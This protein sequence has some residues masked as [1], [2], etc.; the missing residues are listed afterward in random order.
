MSDVLVYVILGITAGSV[1]GLAGVGL[2]LTYRTSG[3]LNF[4]HGALAT[5]GSYLF[6]ELW[7]QA[8]LPWPVAGFLAVVVFGSLLGL[9][10]ELLARRLTTVPS[11]IVVV[12]TVGVLLGITGL[13]T[14]RYTSATLTLDHYLSQSTFEVGGVFISWEQL[15]IV[16][17]GI[18]VAGSM[19]W[20][21][22]HTRIGT[23]MRGVVDDP[24]LLELTGFDAARVRRLAW[25]LGGMVACFS[26]VLIAPTIGLNP[27]LLTYLVVQAFGAAAIGRFKSLPLTFVGGWIIGIVAAWGGKYANQYPVLL[28]LPASVPF[29]AL[30]VVLIISKPGSLPGSEL[31]RRI[32]TERFSALPTPVVAVL[33]FAA[34]AF[35]VGVPGLVGPKLPVYISGAGFL[36]VFLSLGLLVKLAGQASLCHGALVAV[37]AATF[38]R[39]S[40]DL[41]LPWPVAVLCAGLVTV[42]VGA[43]VAI[44]AIRL[45]GIYLALA[46]FA[47]GLL[48]ENLVYRTFLL[49]GNG[50]AKPVT[51][52]D[53][54]GVDLSTDKAYF[55]VAVG[56]AVATALVFVVL[57]RSRLGRIL[58]AL[59]DS[60][61][62][63]QTFGNS[64]T[65]TLVLVFCISA[66]FAGVAGAVLS[67][68]TRGAGT[69]DYGS[70]SSL[71]WIA[72]LA[73][74][75]PRLLSSA[76]IAAGL[77]AVL[78]AYL[79]DDALD[80]QPVGFGV[81]AVITALAAAS[82]FD[83][84]GRVRAD[85]AGSARVGAPSPVAARRHDRTSP[86]EARGARGG[87]VMTVVR[88]APEDVLVIDG[89]EVRFGGVRAVHDLSLEAPVGRI[90]GL[91]GP[92]GAGKSTTF[93]VCSGFVKATAGS[94]R[95]A[96][97]D[98]TSASISS[99]AHCGIGRTFQR[100]E[101]FDT[102]TVREN[103]AVGREARMAGASILRQLVAGRGEQAVVAERVVAAL[104]LCGLDAVADHRAGSLSTGQRRLVELARALAGD[105]R[106]LLLD[107]PSSGLDV[108][109]SR[110]FAEL[111]RHVVDRTGVGILLVEHD[112]RVIADVCDYVYVLDFG[113]LIHEGTPDDVLA[114]ET[115]RA[116]YLGTEPVTRRSGTR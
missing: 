27:Q 21:L 110:R 34:A 51:R 62:A 32:P 72:V 68:G 10:M 112:M 65:T 49:F 33:A 26:G 106:L 8:G 58:R 84:V 111:L 4:A 3:V 79:P 67:A 6:Y 52:P 93:N 63:L 18:A 14:V 92:N 95:F 53:L 20:L 100:M 85:L 86:V 42:P 25:M 81:V 11:E 80:W 108:T 70:F 9:G 7:V 109:E 78:P 1:Y 16:L 115:V 15:F 29:V 94:V 30:F 99:R 105:F 38:S 36:I 98:L 59:A 57:Q 40:V 91:I 28:G 44:P 69:A 45:R 37:G 23:A 24:D 97:T 104:S 90:T 47:F 56:I 5:A 43:V 66:F 41:G 55:Y 12:A 35:V 31:R 96:G 82:R 107:E 76:V 71:V 2:V 101:L 103:V 102:L 75:G 13:A 77:L 87:A 48:M 83:L 88:R 50:T 64:A 46:T 73:L 22:G 113:E 17:S 60:P 61:T 114:S 39:F 116:A 54:P 74:S 89:L 19:T